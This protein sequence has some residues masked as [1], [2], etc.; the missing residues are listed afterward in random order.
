[1]T[2]PDLCTRLGITLHPDPRRVIVKLFIPGE[3]AGIPLA[4]ST[5][6][7]N[8]EPVSAAPRTPN[9]TS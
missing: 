6:R 3:D 9:P 5:T 2:T 1:M 7:A 4:R 8:G